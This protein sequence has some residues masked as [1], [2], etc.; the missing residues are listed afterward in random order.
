MA[1]QKIAAWN[2]WSNSCYG[3]ILRANR[4]QDDSATKPVLTSAHRP[5]PV[6]R[7]DF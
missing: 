6:Y 1:A 7:P 3:P 2:W 5:F 4:E